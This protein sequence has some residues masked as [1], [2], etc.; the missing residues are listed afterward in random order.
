[1]S[2]R[3]LTL[4]VAEG[5]LHAS[6]NSSPRLSP[7]EQK[8]ALMCEKFLREVLAYKFVGPDY[9]HVTEV[10]GTATI[11][12][13]PAIVM[14]WHMNGNV[15]Q[16][17]SLNRGT[18]VDLI[19]SVVEAVK[20]F[21]TKYPRLVH[22]D[23]RPSNIVV[24]NDGRVLISS[25]ASAHV[26]GSAKLTAKKINGLHR[27]MAPELIVIDEDDNSQPPASTFESDMWAL[28]CTTS[29]FITGKVPYEFRRYSLQVVPSIAKGVIPYHKASF[30]NAAEEGG[31]MWGEE[32]WQILEPCWEMDPTCRLTITGLQASLRRMF[33]IA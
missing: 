21:H 4:N 12:G 7:D 3:T 10:M 15:E 27:W 18:A 31:V 30:V 1:M 32:L 22:G 13:K 16:Y 24:G 25:L 23:L 28:T 6:S 14:R 2:S 5:A 9:P 11:G 26:P 8:N 19:M 20:Y 33:D 17:T 29:Q